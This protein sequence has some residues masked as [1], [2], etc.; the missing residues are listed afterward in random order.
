MQ[1]I[2]EFIT[3]FCCS[4]FTGAALYVSVVEHPARMEG[5]TELAVTEFVPS[6]RRAALMQ[7]S[8]AIVG[9]LSSIIAYVSG[10]HPMWL[11][12]GTLLFAVVPLTLVVIMPTNKL[13]LD[14]SLDKKSDTARQLLVRWGR[15]HAVRTILSLLALALMLYLVI[16]KIRVPVVV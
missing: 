5:G 13:L 4:L 1:A 7:A 16:A 15:L 2:A 3:I 8:L 9:F 6:Y 14:P 11:L 10:S 12:G